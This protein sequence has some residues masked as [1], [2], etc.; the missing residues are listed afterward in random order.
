[1]NKEVNL[2]KDPHSEGD[3]AHEVVKKAQVVYSSM[4]AEKRRG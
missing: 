3:I 1:M 2:H 4:A